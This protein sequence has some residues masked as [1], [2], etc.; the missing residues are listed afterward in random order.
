[1]EVPLPPFGVAWWRRWGQPHPDCPLVKGIDVGH[2]ENESSPPGPLLFGR[3][4][5][6]IQEAITDRK[7]G[8]FG[9]GSPVGEP[10]PQ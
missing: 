2:V 1:M 3:L 10:E 7:V 4:G 6:E 8:E 9:P 5:N